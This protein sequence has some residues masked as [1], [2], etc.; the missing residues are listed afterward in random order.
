MAVD[1][2]LTVEIVTPQQV[3]YSGRAESITVPGTE[4]PF[5]VLYNHA[6]IISSL[7]IG[8]IK[9]VDE[10]GM[11]KVFATSGGFAE[12]SH[13]KV[14]VIVE[15]I[16]DASAIDVN[17]A[18]A[19]LDRAEELIRRPGGEGN[20]EEARKAIA[21]ALNRLQIARKYAGASRM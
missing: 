15:S 12:V 2:L 7:E 4:G 1:K 16:E 13:N 9:I 18:N 3:E 21:R 10:H 11:D 8:M 5:Q 20:V 6:P 19:A 17:R 14:S